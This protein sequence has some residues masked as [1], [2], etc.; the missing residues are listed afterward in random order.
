MSGCPVL[1]FPHFP[2][3]RAPQPSILPKTQ[4]AH[5]AM[6]YLYF[7]PNA[8]GAGHARH[9]LLAHLDACASRAH[10][11]ELHGRLIRA[12]LAADPAV[13]SRLVALLA[14]PSAGRGDMRRAR[15]VL[16]GLP[17]RWRAR[18]CGSRSRVVPRRGRER[19]QEK[20]AEAAAKARAVAGS[21]RRQCSGQS[22]EWD[23]TQRPGEVPDGRGKHR[24]NKVSDHSS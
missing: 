18:R 16:D 24:Q 1:S 20:G 11:A 15:R 22:M 13:A 4:L 8:A 5:A 21:N 2:K 17:P 19:G 10:V 7:R 14:S 9:P 23:T 12:H 3:N 6:R